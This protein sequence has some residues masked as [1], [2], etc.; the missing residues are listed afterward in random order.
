[1]TNPADNS[2]VFSDWVTV[3][4]TVPLLPLPPNNERA[5]LVTERLIIRPPTEDDLAALYELRTLPE[6]MRNTKTGT[7]DVDIAFTRGRLVPFLAPGDA[8]TFNFAICLRE[9]GDNKLIG[10][11]GVHIFHS[12]FGWPELGYMF[13]SAHW[14]KGYATE[15]VRGF[16]QMYSKL[17]RPETPQ[18][19][20]VTRCTLPA[21]LQAKAGPGTAEKSDYDDDPEALA[22]T[23]TADTVV[24]EEKLTAIVAVRNAESNR[25]VT[26]GGF[27]RFMQ[28]SKEDGWMPGSGI[29]IMLNVYH[30][31][32]SKEASE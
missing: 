16:L 31:F 19:L 30:Y 29:D 22:R 7:I 3:L 2:S 10:I 21:D 17:P 5:A 15:F 8:R 24:V 14:G 4:T 28:F 23:V 1:M 6:V 20:R 18:P 9:A 26:K 32:P 13:H 27:E 12:V 25:V 11:G